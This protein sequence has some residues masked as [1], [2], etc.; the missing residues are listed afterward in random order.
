[1]EA[2]LAVIR[3][4]WDGHCLGLIAS[5]AGS[6]LFVLDFVAAT[7]SYGRFVIKCIF[8]SSYFNLT[9]CYA[10]SSLVFKATFFPL[11]S[12]VLALL[13]DES[14]LFRTTLRQEGFHD[15]SYNVNWMPNLEQ[16]PREV[17]RP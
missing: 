5:F 14:T 2:F 15:I 1:M 7:L 8:V 16:H 11:S 12:T 13:E 10:T 17:P 6:C 3:G 4:R 9:L